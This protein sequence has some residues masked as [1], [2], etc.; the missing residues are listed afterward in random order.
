MTKYVIFV[1]AQPGQAAYLEPL[2]KDW[3]NKGYKEW[4]IYS[5]NKA[6]SKK[7]KTTLQS[8]LL[9]FWEEQSDI[10]H[11]F[12]HYP[13]KLI[14][15]SA[16]RLQ[17]ILDTSTFAKKYQ[18]P[19]IQVIDSWN[20]YASRIFESNPKGS[21][22]DAVTVIDE[23]AKDKAVAEGLPENIIHCT[24]HP[25]W[26]E[27]I[28]IKTSPQSRSRVVFASQPLSEIPSMKGLGFDE[29]SVWNFLKDFQKQNPDLIEELVYKP[30]PSQKKLPN[31]M[32]GS[33]R[34]PFTDEDTLNSC[35]TM[36]S[37]FSAIMV[38]GLFAGQ[39][40]IGLQP[41]LLQ[42]NLCPLTSRALV[43][44]VTSYSVPELKQALQAETL[45]DDKLGQLMQAVEGSIDKLKVVINQFLV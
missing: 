18:I 41:N 29:V 38:E 33:I 19:H 8:F 40:V 12:R 43:P 15:N 35:G 11:V 17:P 37:M 14:I 27:R 28:K 7:L 10:E 31:N 36:V 20:D 30:H 21:L 3:I 4:C 22:P 5:A 1:I 39:H 32:S 9:P 6:L 24:G 13:P 2:W 25:A 42:T 44:L 16:C 34:F 23:W 45:T 26:E